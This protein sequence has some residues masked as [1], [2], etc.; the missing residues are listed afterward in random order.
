[1]LKKFKEILVRRRGV[2][3][4]AII[5][6]RNCEETIGPVLEHLK[7]NQIKV[8]L[9]DNGSTDRTLEIVDKFRHDP[10]QEVNSIPYEGVFRLTQLLQWKESVRERIDSQWIIHQDGD[11]IIESPRPGESLRQ[12]IQRQHK[13]NRAVIDCDEFVFVPRSEEENYAGTDFRKKMHHYYHFAPGGRLLHRIIR[14]E[15]K[16]GG[17]V[18]SGG[19]KVTAEESSIAREKARLRHYMGLSLDSLR[20]QY[21]SRSFA[22]EEL[23]R[24]WHFNRFPRNEHFIQPPDPNRLLNLQAD[25]WSTSTKE[26]QH[27]IFAP[28]ESLTPPNLPP[29]DPDRPPMPFIVGV[30]RSGTTLLRLIMDAHPDMAIPPEAHWLVQGIRYLEEH[31]WS[32]DG[33]WEVLCAHYGW[34]QMPFDKEK[35]GRLF[36]PEK[37]I[38][39]FFRSIYQSYAADLNASRIGDKT[40]IN[41][42]FMLKIAEHFPEARFIHLIRDGRDVALSYRKVD[43]GPGSDPRQAAMLWTWRIAFARTQ[44]QFLPHYR[45]VKYEDLIRNTREV[46][47]SIDAF[48]DLDF[49]PQQMNYHQKAKERLSETHYRS[50]QQSE[51]DW[52]R[53]EKLFAKTTSVPD[54]SRIGCWKQEMSK[55]DVLAFEAV[56][57][58]LL[59]DL[60]YPLSG[61]S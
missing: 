39:S 33:L 28:T 50:P 31:S 4:C 55:E 32:L 61:Y 37:G 42:L 26:S 48:I 24:G 38:A 5:M 52:I 36:E 57:G 16:F 6:T 18:D 10:V 47:E 23:R 58:D 54:S 30:G 46:V 19:H 21:L 13:A 34:D 35:L 22:G 17:W 60:G 14:N 12:F 29:S 11:E 44:A 53:L 20:R 56:A 40:P 59:V 9:G 8:V 7:A 51:K 25:G 1:M 45:E 27:L 3:I 43:F 41:N 49:H 2:S 15:Q